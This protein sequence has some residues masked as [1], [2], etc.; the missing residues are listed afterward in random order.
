MLDRFEGHLSGL[1]NHLLRDLAGSGTQQ[2]GGALE[3]M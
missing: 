3:S 1:F 2:L